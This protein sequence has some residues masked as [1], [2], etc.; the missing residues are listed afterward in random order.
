MK[1][2]PDVLTYLPVFYALWAIFIQSVWQNL[3]CGAGITLYDPSVSLLWAGK[4]A[5]FI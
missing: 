1:H 2:S 4:V 5:C 3:R